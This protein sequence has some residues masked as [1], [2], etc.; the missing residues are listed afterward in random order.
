MF[1]EA[2]CTSS[3]FS[4]HHMRLSFT[5]LPRCVLACVAME[6]S[7]KPLKKKSKVVLTFFIAVSNYKAFMTKYSSTY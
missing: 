6:P 7:A 4:R 2:I 3:V 1:T 5:V